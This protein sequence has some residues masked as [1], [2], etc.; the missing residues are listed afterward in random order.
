MSLF[1]QQP[2]A[3]SLMT[4]Q[5]VNYLD[6]V[7]C[8]VFYLIY[9]RGQLWRY[10]NLPAKNNKYTVKSRS[11]WDN[12]LQFQITCLV[13]QGCF[14]GGIPV[15]LHKKVYSQMSKLLGQKV[16]YLSGLPWRCEMWCP[17][18]PAKKKNYSQISKLLGQFFT[19]S[20][21]AFHRINIVAPD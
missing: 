11:C 10:P 19:S 13:S 16:F 8:K 2:G 9:L 1:V 6:R 20:N 12:F 4:S 5:N 14:I 15:L 7:D 18:P 21:V 3:F 17:C